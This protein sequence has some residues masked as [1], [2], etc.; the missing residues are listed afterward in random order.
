M[1]SIKIQ[2]ENSRENTNA[3]PAL[4]IGNASALRAS[5]GVHNKKIVRGKLQSSPIFSLCLG[6]CDKCNFVSRLYSGLVV[7]PWPGLQ[8]YCSGRSAQTWE[9]HE[10]GIRLNGAFKLWPWTNMPLNCQGQSRNYWNS[11]AWMLFQKLG[12]SS[13]EPCPGCLC[14]CRCQ[15]HN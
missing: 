7:H 3:L 9:E 15:S 6:A 11:E 8:L 10:L 5:R 13:A 14:T 4:P 2:S 12:L 1:F